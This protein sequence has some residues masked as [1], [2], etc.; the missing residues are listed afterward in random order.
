MKI[1]IINTFDTKGGAAVASYRLH[2]ALLKNSIDSTMIV[3]TKLSDDWTIIAD[4]SKIKRGI[5]AT[6]GAIDEGIVKLFYS[7]KSIFSPAFLPLSNIINKI[8]ELNPD[9][10]HLHWICGGMLRIEDLAKIKVPIVWS[11]HDMWAFT[12]G[13]HY[14]NE[15]AKYKKHCNSCPILNSNTQKDISYKI[16]KRKE[17]VYSKLNNLTIIGLSKWMSECAKQSY[18]L[19]EKD[20]INLPNP[21]DTNLFKPFDKNK[22]RELWNLPKDKKLILFGAMSATSDK[23]KGYDKLIQAL[24]E[25]QMNN[26]DIE[27]VVFGSSKPKQNQNF[28]FNTHYLGYLNDNISLVTLYSSV[29]VMIVPSLQENLSNAII[30]SLSCATPVVAFDIGGNADMIEH[31][32]NGYLAKPFNTKD[33][34]NGIEWILQ[35]KDYE[36]LSIRARSKVLEEFDSD[37]V[38][39]KYIK[40]YEDVLLDIN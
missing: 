31:K 29:D 40:L 24:N 3:Q 39:K 7:P 37:I 36:K 14:D 18:L 34:A 15:C 9:I 26:E 35:N 20:I 32:N 10:V 21:I 2:K 5:N 16:F 38:A 17:K 28:K 6:R 25:L 33:L 12:G 23:R 22:A 8:N 27:L 30:E 19:K 11:L 13:C 4:T 1:A